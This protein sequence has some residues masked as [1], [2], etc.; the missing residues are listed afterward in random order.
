MHLDTGLVVTYVP[1]PVVI[2]YD[3]G[4][5]KIQV[6]QIE[7]SFDIIGEVFVIPLTVDPT[8]GTLVAGAGGVGGGGQA[9]SVGGAGCLGALSAT[10]VQVS[11][12]F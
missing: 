10:L 12:C 3:S 1:V 7:V 5:V 11:H 8:A 6:L 9:G 2:S 4:G